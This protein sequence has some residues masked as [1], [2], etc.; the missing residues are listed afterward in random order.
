LQ[1]V[2]IKQQINIFVQGHSAFNGKFLFIYELFD[3]F[4]GAPSARAFR[5]AQGPEF[6]RGARVEGKLHLLRRG[7]EAPLRINP[8]PIGLSLGVERVDYVTWKNTLRYGEEG[9]GGWD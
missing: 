6:N 5:Q 2:D 7:K 9:S 4:S 1:P 8:E 3:P